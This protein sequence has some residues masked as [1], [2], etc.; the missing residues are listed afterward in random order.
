MLVLALEGPDGHV[1]TVINWEH[2]TSMRP[3]SVLLDFSIQTGGA[4]LS[5]RPIASPDEAYEK[6]GV[7]H[8]TMPNTP[9]LVARTASKRISSALAPFIKQL[10]RLDRPP[11]GWLGLDIDP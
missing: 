7:L 8:M 2:I 10:A 5:S 11:A 6:L 3:G 9:A 1:P 4:S